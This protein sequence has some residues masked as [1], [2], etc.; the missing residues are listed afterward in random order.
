MNEDEITIL[1][2]INYTEVK[3]VLQ[4]FLKTVSKLLSKCTALRICR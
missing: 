2:G 4:N 3:Q 1:N